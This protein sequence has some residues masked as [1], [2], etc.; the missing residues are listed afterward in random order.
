[1]D[2]LQYQPGQSAKKHTYL[3]SLR[4]LKSDIEQ[5][6]LNASR[7]SHRSDIYNYISRLLSTYTIYLDYEELAIYNRS[8]LDRRWRHNNVYIIIVVVQ[9]NIS[10]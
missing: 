2:H 5:T 1:M 7:F 9:H 4:C 8:H 10:Y 6:E 3:V